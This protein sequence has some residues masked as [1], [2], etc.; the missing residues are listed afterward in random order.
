M[1]HPSCEEGD[2]I[3]ATTEGPPYV[4]SEPDAAGNLTWKGYSVDLL[5]DMMR[6]LQLTYCFNKTDSYGTLMD[7]G[8]WN[9][10]MEEV[11]TGRADI[12][13]Q[14]LTVTRA[15][16]KVVLFTSPFINSAFTAIMRREP[17]YDF[18]EYLQAFDWGLLGLIVGAVFFTSVSLYALM[19]LQRR[20]V[21]AD[22]EDRFSTFEETFWFCLKSL[23]NQG[24]ELL[25]LTFAA[26]F[27]AVVWWIFC[28]IIM[29]AFTANLAAYLSKLHH[30]PR[31]ISQL[32]GQTKIRYGCVNSTSDCDF[33]RLSDNPFYQNAWYT[34]A[35]LWEGKT[36]FNDCKTAFEA[37]ARE[38]NLA[39]FSD[40]SYFS[41]HLNLDC[42]LVVVPD[43]LANVGS[44]F[45]VHPNRSDLRDRLSDWIDNNSEQLFQKWK[46]WWFKK[47]D[48]NGRCRFE[49]DGG[50]ITLDKLRGLFFSLFA[51]I[52]GAYFLVIFHAC[53]VQRMNTSGLERRLTKVLGAS[54]KRK[55]REANMDRPKVT[56]TTTSSTT[57]APSREEMTS[58][59]RK[60]PVTFS[61]MSA[62][63]RSRLTSV[64]CSLGSYRSRRHRSFY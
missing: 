16:A 62:A 57:G 20:L 24:W 9:G 44:A 32:L 11:R 43:S 58:V 53:V 3:V 13:L 33:F 14:K 47:A 56:T 59:R 6:H 8:R 52:A 23:L 17:M 34:M 36:I 22:N 7:D 28:L 10:I 27:M 60:S 1:F 49:D 37:V 21:A 30:V 48:K 29:A 61:L 64:P 50:K 46:E 54:V 18:F 31:A 41:Y 51:C 12:G 40:V 45:A 42:D 19:Q 25:P 15:R 2:L 4:Y 55:P 35:E 26:R 63:P 5:D 38:E 39:L